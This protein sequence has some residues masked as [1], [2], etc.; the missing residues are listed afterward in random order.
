[1][2]EELNALI[3]AELT[4]WKKDNSYKMKTFEIL[5]WEIRQ[6]PEWEWQMNPLEMSDRVQRKYFWMTADEFTFD[7]DFDWELEEWQETYTYIQKN[8]FTKEEKEVI[9]VRNIET[10]NT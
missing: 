6:V 9:G 1:M 7:E 4:K 2:N 5:E 3:Q 10:P 8:P